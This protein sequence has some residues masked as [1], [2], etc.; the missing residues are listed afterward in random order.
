MANSVDA[1]YESDVL[2]S[3]ILVRLRAAEAAA[4]TPA[5]GSVDF[6]LHAFNGASRRRFGIH[7]R[8]VGLTRLSGQAPDQVVRRAFLPV[9]TAAALDAIAVSSVISIGGVDWTV[10]GKQPESSV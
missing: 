10:R 5:G 7:A 4:Y 2:G 1:P 8:G 9:G 3:T 6:P